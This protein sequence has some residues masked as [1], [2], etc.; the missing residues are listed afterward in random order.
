MIRDDLDRAVV[1]DVHDATAHCLPVGK[2]DE[3]VV[4][5]S[6]AG[7]WLVHVASMRPPSGQV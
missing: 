6:P 4:A 5:W 3:D 2:L 1:L 7:L